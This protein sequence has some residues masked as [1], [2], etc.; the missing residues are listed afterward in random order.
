MAEMTSRRRCACC[1]VFCSALLA[2]VVVLVAIIMKHKSGGKTSSLVD[3]DLLENKLVEAVQEL[4]YDLIGKFPGKSANTLPINTSSAGIKAWTWTNKSAFI[5]ETRNKKPFILID[6]PAIWWKA[7]SWDLW[8]IS[9]RWPLLKNVLVTEEESHMILQQSDES[10]D[11]DGGMIGVTKNDASF[12]DVIY[13][14]MFTNFLFHAASPKLYMLY[15]SN[16]RVMESIAKLSQE[17]SWKRFRIVE[18]VLRTAK[19]PEESSLK[20]P[21]PGITFA[22]PG[23]S[24]QARYSTMHTCRVQILGIG[25][26]LL[27]PP[28]RQSS[29]YLYPSIHT[30]HQQSQVVMDE[31]LNQDIHP[32]DSDHP[33]FKRNVF[34]SI[35]AVT[36]NPGEVLY[37]PPYWLVRSEFPVLSVFIDVPS[38]SE[39]MLHLKEA[40]FTVV[41][42]GKMS[43]IPNERIIGAQVYLMHFLSRIHGLKSPKKFAENHYKSRYSTIY[44]KNGLFMRKHDFKCF[45]DQTEYQES[46]IKRINQKKL[47]ASAQHAADCVNDKSITSGIKWIFIG[48]Y[49]DRIAR[50]AMQDPDKAVLFLTSCLQFDS[51]LKIIEEVEGPSVMRVGENAVDENGKS[52]L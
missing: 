36:L 49:V 5:D 15:S 46:V 16:Y 2:V 3:E 41:P 39:E 12:P 48:D 21:T 38:L 50:W 25:R 9:T 29:L 28:S 44:P 35:R 43:D 31:E 30:S 34:S 47:E 37:V 26:Y 52:S 4:R 32:V 27:F 24:L 14:M 13:E 18:P 33:L 7:L 23:I 45:S 22:H 51:K 17:T 11:T 8:N 6:S 1:G 42:L 19:L 20:Q 40:E 10:G